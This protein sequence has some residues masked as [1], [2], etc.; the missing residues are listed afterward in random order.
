MANVIGSVLIADDDPTILRTLKR[1]LSALGYDVRTA[2]NGNVA[3]EDTRQ[4]SFD[5]IIADIDM[6]GMTGI[7]MLKAV[8]ASDPDVPV[9]LITG[10]PGLD[11]AM[12]AVRYGA[13]RY[14]PKPI[15]MDELAESLA[16]A[17]QVHR[18]ARIKR[19]AL[20]LFGENDRQASD[21]AGLERDFDCAMS[22]MWMAFQPIV[23]W[24][25]KKIIGYEALLRSVE[26]AL[27][28]PG[29]ILSAAERLDRMREL[30]N[31]VREASAAEMTDLAPDLTVF[32]NLAAQ[33]LADE[34][35][36]S[37]VAPLSKVASRVVLEI[38]ER[39]NLDGI[40][41]IERR[42]S[43]LRELGFRLAVDDLGAGY[44]GLTSFVKIRPDIVKVDMSLVRNIHLDAAKRK[45]VGALIDLS[46]SMGIQTV[47]EGIENADELA[48]V[49]EL[50]ADLMQGFHFA[51]P[52]I[53]FPTVPPARFDLKNSES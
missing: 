29:A 15:E 10:D 27:P 38:T 48:V 19:E 17:V 36:Y 49:V 22:S 13:F 2:D 46:T 28:H 12:R 25:Q 52:G 51:V 35:L 21:L 23:S 3:V 32:V 6:P 24:R 5:A 42:M 50:G 30:G 45:L 53:P 34:S 16:F 31:R 47:I 9:L 40:S 11:T 14:L 39:V 7:E 44:A 18:L 33:D 43:A 20:A 1:A 37:N 4:F 26:P 8:R 41:D